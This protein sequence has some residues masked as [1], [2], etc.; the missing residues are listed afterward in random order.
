MILAFFKKLPPSISVPAFYGLV[1]I[2]LIVRFLIAS[3]YGALILVLG[4]YVYVAEFTSINPLTP[5]E[6]GLWLVTLSQG[7]K[8]ALL[9]SFVTVIGFVVAF[10]TATVNWRNQMRAQLKAQAAGEI[11][12]FFALVSSNITTASMYVESLIETVNE[13]QKGESIADASFSVAYQQDTAKE[14]LAARDVLSKASID[15]HR[16]IGRN[17]NLLSTGWGLLAS[18]K[19]AAD[20]LSNVTKVM[21]LHIPVV[22]LDDPNHI[23]SFLN[24]LNVTECNKFLEACNLSHGKISGLSGGIQ[25][26][27]TAPIWG[28][29]L[30][31]FANLIGSRK[32][33]KESMKEF[34]NKLNDGI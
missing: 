30:T 25:G 17:H 11:E 19:L 13:I 3:T 7:Y 22:N 24:Q 1:S 10:H 33:F 21:W 6:M 9:S 16:L 28:F 20:S 27:L 18:T 15:V 8:V 2:A 34:H 29:S 5:S 4:F 31:M 23:Q 32:E 14:F 12:S 26:H